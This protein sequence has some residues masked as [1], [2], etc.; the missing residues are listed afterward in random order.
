MEQIEAYDKQQT[1]DA[2]HNRDDEEE[3]RIGPSRKKVVPAHKKVLFYDDSDFEEEDL[4]LENEFEQNRLHV[5]SKIAMV[6]RFL[7]E[8]CFVLVYK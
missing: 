4:E 3:V 5:M 8:N 1:K 2:N 7:F 6:S